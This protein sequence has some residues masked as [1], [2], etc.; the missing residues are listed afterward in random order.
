MI[1]RMKAFV[2]GLL[3]LIG[4][5]QHTPAPVRHAEPPPPGEAGVA[6]VAD[7]ARFVPGATYCPGAQPWPTGERTCTGDADCPNGRCYPNGVPNYSGMCG[8]APQEIAKCSADRDCGAHGYCD[9]TYE[10]HGCGEVITA[11]CK[12]KC[13]STSC[14]AGEVCRPSGRC[15]V[16]PCTEGYA[17]QPGWKCDAHA[18]I[19]DAHGCAQPPCTATSCGPN[20]HCTGTVCDVKP[21]SSSADCDCGACFGGR[22]APRPGECGPATPPAPPP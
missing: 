10:H 15:E 17:C 6:L 16:Q 5:E 3:V 22:C 2:V 7:A 21:C 18:S 4:C 12:P 19:T 11:Q 8:V 9:H 14:K 13:S 20:Q 1:H